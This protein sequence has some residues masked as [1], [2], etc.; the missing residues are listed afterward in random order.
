MSTSSAPFSSLHSLELCLQNQ[1]KMSEKLI[2][3]Q[4][5]SK[6]RECCSKRRIDCD[7][8]TV[9]STELNNILRRFYAEVKSNIH[10]RPF[11]TTSEVEVKQATPFSAMA[12]KSIKVK[13]FKL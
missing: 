4:N 11:T 13:S 7:L 5:S 1:G 12:P 8:N 6:I 9:C 2:E 10:S 3:E